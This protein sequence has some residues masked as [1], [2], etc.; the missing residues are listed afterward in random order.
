MTTS[1][2]I[3]APM[4]LVLHYFFLQWSS[5]LKLIKAGYKLQCPNNFWSRVL[6]VLKFEAALV[7]MLV[8]GLEKS[9]WN[10]VCDSQMHP[11]SSGLRYI[12]IHYFNLN[13]NRN[14]WTSNEAYNDLSCLMLRAKKLLLLR[15][16]LCLHYNQSW[17]EVT[18]ALADSNLKTRQSAFSQ[19]NAMIC[20]KQRRGLTKRLTQ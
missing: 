3:Y 11:G 10:R 2:I 17:H 19:G 12:K 16:S 6:R 1:F 7:I 5:T 8:A 4:S 14:H 20:R 13:L 15:V 18:E 9:Q